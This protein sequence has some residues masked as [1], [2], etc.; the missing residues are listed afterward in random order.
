MGGDCT[1]WVYPVRPATFVPGE[2]TLAVETRPD[3]VRRLARGTG[4]LLPATLLGNVLLLI[5]DLY[6]NGVLGTAGYG[7]FK[8]VSR[9]MGL[10][11]FV[12]LLG[13]ENAV[14]RYLAGARA[15]SGGSVVAK[16]AAL[17]GSAGVVGAALLVA[18]ARWTAGW[19]DT[20]PETALALQIAAISL[21]FAGLRMVWVAA[22][23][24]WGDVAPRAMLMFLAWPLAQ[25]VGVTLLGS[26]GVAGVS[27]A[28]TGSM[29]LGALLAGAL[30]WRAGT[31]A[32]ALTHGPIQTSSVLYNDGPK[33]SSSELALDESRERGV[34]T[35]DLLVFAA[36]LWVQGIVMALYTW[37]DQVLLAGLRSAED[38][39]IY[40]P[41][42]TLAPLFGL[43]LGALNGM[44]APMIA[45]RSASGQRG[46]LQAL[47][48]TVTRW[49]V[50][51]ALPTTVLALV[52]PELVLGLWPHGSPDAANA[53]R[54]TALAQLVCTGVGSVNYLLIMAGHQRLVLWNGVPAVVLN[55]AASCLLIPR[56]GPLGAALANGL[57]MMF[58]NVVG[59]LQVRATL[60]ISPFP[61]LG[62]GRAL[63]AGIVAGLAAALVPSL[64]LAGLAGRWADAGLAGLLTLGVFAAV[65][66][67]LGLDDD[68]RVVIH[69][70]RAKLPFLNRMVK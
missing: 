3:D 1:A 47:Y 54:V 5:L 26:S 28:Y 38:A 20:S 65:L 40:G 25:I 16:A 60:G 51:L 64:H 14:I 9:V 7:I 10:A 50:I 48:R 58:A 67:A 34:S 24:G 52:R 43:G 32:G 46:Q 2:R 53:L 30:A 59:F 66:A 29:A 37:S 4:I 41:V 23:Q 8:A 6:V 63:I 49:A 19:V 12:A 27:A 68:D 36:P 21:P 17:V 44:F 62:I 61:R 45:E 22:A 39:G 33:Q 35:R 55:L 13:M 18:T 31:R 69:A 70:I 57:A 56:Y 42:A 15:V 11:G